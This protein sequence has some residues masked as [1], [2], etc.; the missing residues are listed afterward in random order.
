[1]EQIVLNHTFQQDR[2]M[3]DIQFQ[4]QLRAEELIKQNQVNYEYEPI[5]QAVIFQYKTE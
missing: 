1:M 2:D 5:L 4:Q 3:S